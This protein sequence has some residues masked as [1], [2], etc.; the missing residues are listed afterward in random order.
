MSFL[1]TQRPGAPKPSPSKRARKRRPSNGSIGGEDGPQAGPSNQQQNE[2][3]G[4]GGEENE[5]AG[6]KKVAGRAAGNAGDSGLG[7]PVEHKYHAE[8]AQ[9]VRPARHVQ[10]IAYKA[11]S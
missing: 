3:A 6:K 8:I 9:M 5:A 2:D 7:G 10:H 4:S 1:Q 11:T